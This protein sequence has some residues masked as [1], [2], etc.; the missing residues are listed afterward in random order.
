M[1]P[2]YLFLI[3]SVISISG[4]AQ[5]RAAVK[6]GEE[7]KL[8]KGSTDLKVVFAD[9]TGA[10]L[11]ENHLAGKALHVAGEAAT[12]LKVN[13]SLAEVYRHDFKK[14]LKGRNFV[15]FFSCG[16]DLFIFSSDYS[17]GDKQLAI[18]A[19][20]VDK[21]SGELA[22]TW[23]QIT[24]L[25][26]ENKNDVTNIRLTYNADSTKMVIVSSVEGKERNEYK[27]QELDIDLKPS[28][29]LITISNEFESKKFRLED[30]IY[31]INHKVILVGRVYE[32]AEGKAKKEKF[33]DFDHYNIRVYNEKGKQESEINTSI[34][35]KWLSS[36]RIL[37]EGNENLILA[38]FY[39]NKKRGSIDGLLVQR[40]DI[41]SGKVVSTSNKQINNSLLST[42]QADV[43]DNG[44]KDDDKEDKATKEELEKMKK[45]GEGFSK[46]MQ[47]SR[48]FYT[49]DGGL[50]ILAES[51]ENYSFTNSTYTAG[52]SNI[53]GRWTTS[54]YSVYEYGDLLMCKID[55]KGDVSWLDVLPKFQ[56]ELYKTAQQSGTVAASFLPA[57]SLFEEFN[58]PFYAGFGAMKVGSNIK[59]I[60]NDNPKNAEVTQAGQK[61]KGIGRLDRSDC[62]MLDVDEVTGKVSRKK[63]FSNVE[64]PT[65]MPRLGSVIGNDMYLVGR[66]NRAL[67][68]TRIAVGKISVK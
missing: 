28:G 42:A 33:L 32:Y 14:E 31:T 40:L 24:S 61:I 48:I 38:A 25:Q 9:K 52:S 43:N 15:Q 35:D 68:K 39:S 53:P 22:G 57:G 5:D 13:T 47:F 12:L 18:F 41:A 36:T 21:S 66:T 10:Y 3:S 50:V 64:L 58:M 45:E 20:K 19:A 8:R 62:F 59:I 55:A 65:A 51:R 7:F 29:K 49:S 46:Y 11:E 4:F 56:K 67:A 60:F 1:K 30:L 37:Q 6:W 23:E 2:I 26:Q 63:L 34:N 54:T 17:K 27:V 16:D 44:D